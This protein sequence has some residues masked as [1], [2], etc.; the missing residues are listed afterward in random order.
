MASCNM[1][2]QRFNVNFALVCMHKSIPLADVPTLTA[3]MSPVNF[4]NLTI[5]SE[6]PFED[7]IVNASITNLHIRGENGCPTGP[8]KTSNISVDENSTSEFSWSKETQG[9]IIAAFYYGLAISQIPS[10]W[11]VDRFG[12]KRSLLL[13]QFLLSALSIINP[14]TAKSGATFLFV[15]RFLQGIVN[16]PALPAINVLSARWSGS[17]ER[18]LLVGIFAA[19]FSLATAIVYPICAFFCENSGWPGIFYFAGGSG[20]LWCLVACF[21]IYEWPE[22]HPRIGSKELRFIQK[23]RAVHYG[24]PKQE[25][26]I[27]S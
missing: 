1:I 21:T 4:T 14:I 2:V 18:S 25:V 5:T 12:S 23:F 3:D 15:V 17:M 19:G 11:M 6:S 9:S 16:G 8:L 7:Q 10:A 27:L 24:G 13:S 26:S 22:D 20:L